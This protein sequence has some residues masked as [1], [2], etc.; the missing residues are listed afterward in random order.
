MVMPLRE[1]YPVARA[2]E[3]LECKV[4]DLLHWAS[5]G[6]INLYVE[7]QHGTGYVHFFGNNVE[8][9]NR[10]LV[11]YDEQDFEEAKILKDEFIKNRLVSD[12]PSF[13][14]NIHSDNCKTDEYIIKTGAIIVNFNGLWALPH[15]F[16]GKTEL[17]SIIPSKYDDWASSNKKM[18][19]SFENDEYISFE[20]DDLYLM[21]RDFKL[22]LDNGGKTLPN[23][24]NGGVKKE[25]IE[26]GNAIGGI[27]QRSRV[28]KPQTDAIKIMVKKLYPEMSGN[29]KRIA[30]ILS[31]EANNVEGMQGVNFDA[32]T[33]SRWLK[34]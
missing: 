28:S 5:I 13:V 8:P 18:F 26:E 11:N 4:E 16:Y 34:D 27:N 15:S 9:E 2:A 30:E 32:E 21:H 22:I 29:Y 31:A 1:Y 20:V 3:L 25:T 33:I 19:I 12:G 6:A 10:N 14:L 7:F 17:Y 23:Y 24:Y